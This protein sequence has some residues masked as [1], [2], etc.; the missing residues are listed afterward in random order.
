MRVQLNS[1]V[2]ILLLL[3]AMQGCGGSGSNTQTTPPQQNPVPML[4]S[5]SPNTGPQNGAALTI[6]ATGSSFVQSSQIAWNGTSLTT[7]FVS[8]T[9]LQA[10][11][12]A[13]SFGDVGTADVTV[14]TPTPGGGTS[15]SLKF[16]ITLTTT[17]VAVLDVGGNDLT[18]DASHQ[19]IYVSVPSAASSNANT[20]TIVDPIAGTV[21]NAQ[22]L[23]AEPGILAIS[24]DDQFLYAGIDGNNSVQRLVLPGLTPD[25]SWSLGTDALGYAINATDIKVQ[26]KAAHTVA[27]VEGIDTG[28]VIY[29]DGVAR[30]NT[31]CSLTNY[32]AFLQWK[33]DGTQLFVKES[34]RGLSILSVDA[35]GTKPLNE[36][37]GAFRGYGL[38]EHFDATTNYVYDDDGEVVDTAT[39]L[40]VGNYP[41]PRC[42]G[43]YGDSPLMAAVDPALG[44]VFFLT[45]VRDS[46]NTRSFQIQ[47]FDQKSFRLIGAFSIANAI[48][49][50]TNFIRWGTAGLA[51]V[52]NMA[53][54]DPEDG[55][56]YLIDGVFVNPSS[57]P[58]T[59]IGTAQS[60][61]A[62]L[63]SVTPLSATVGS[64]GSTVN[65]NGRDFE[66]QSTVL[67]N[68][69]ALSTTRVSNT[70]LQAV[71][72]ASDLTT[73]GVVSLTVMNTNAGAG[74][75][76]ALQFAVNPPPSS[77]NQISILPAG[78]NALVWDAQS[79]KIY[80]SQPGVEGDQG[81]TIAAVDPAGGTV[82]NSVV[83]GSDPDR[84]S[85][86]GDDSYLYVG[87]NGE[88]QIQRL[89]LPALTPDI[90]WH[91][92]SDP[93][94]GAYYAMDVLAAPGAAHT[95]AV[96][97]GIFDVGPTSIGGTVIYDDSTPRPITA[98]GWGSSPYSYASLQWGSD[99]STL[100]APADG[101][102]TDLYVLGVTNQGVSVTKTY[103]WLLTFSGLPFGMD[104]D[105]GTGF[106]YTDGG[107]VVDPVSGTIVGTFN[108]SGLVAADSSLNRVFF[109][110][111][112]SAQAGTADY[113]IQSYDQQ[114]FT[115]LDSITIPNVVGR[116]SAF[117]RWGTNGLAFTSR[118]G[119]STDFRAV[120]PG[121]LYV[122]SG[123][124]VKSD[125]TKASQH[126][127]T[128]EHVRRAW[129]LREGQR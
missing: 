94:D 91:I 114:K 9:E 32:C 121:L 52:T 50:P 125:S 117:I 82:T 107:Q 24:D 12:A 2:V 106:L 18:W 8:G 113:T 76:N 14:V 111:Q 45:G 105:N 51:F 42:L 123:S 128:Q 95:S 53:S 30:P 72:P 90:S 60:P 88:N 58:D 4:T 92:P 86:S 116:P 46:A 48:G 38:H 16:T 29:D 103:S 81:D 36:Y 11:V 108:A 98:P 39:G 1:V 7:T 64:A 77:G 19:K 28:V 63:T 54:Q 109:L 122:V 87:M 35:T 6:T 27:L 20:I 83:I 102:P 126:L 75:S 44:R 112:T 26:P 59:S 104:Y 79:Q 56:L 68:G 124:L 33:A 13:S 31:R 5:I 100:Y 101:T 3:F 99:A 69:N 85:I 127:R 97:L 119:S 37:G 67:W 71:V 62:T 21:G 73:A 115:L 49:T 66:G 110:G 129:N 93:S 65:V 80:V 41:A 47:V 78:G 34:T 118:V 43:C 57:A 23:S 61:I 25:I 70:Q 89:V 40:P 55:K 17:N 74:I 84:L 120:G 22:A 96:N 10:Q 15:Q